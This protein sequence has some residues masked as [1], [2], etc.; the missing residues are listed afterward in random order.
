VEHLEFLGD[1]LE[2]PRKAF[3]EALVKALPTKGTVLI[4]SPYEK[5]ILRKLAVFLPKFKAPFDAIIQRCKD[6]STPFQKRDVVH[7][8]FEGSYSIKYVLPALVPGMGYDHLS[9]GD[10]N[11]AVRAYAQLMDE[12]ISETVKKKIRKDLLAYCGQ[13]TLAMVKLV[14]VLRASILRRQAEG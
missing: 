13:D 11:A 7:P 8:N 1:G 6:L 9:I 14:E 4:Y 3:A 5:V 12:K 2:D 10:G